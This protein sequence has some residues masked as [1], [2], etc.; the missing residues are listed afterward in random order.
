MIGDCLVASNVTDQVLACQGVLDVL[1]VV[2]ACMPIDRSRR[3]KGPSEMS[4]IECLQRFDRRHVRPL[5][6]AAMIG[7]LSDEENPILLD[8]IEDGGPPPPQEL[9]FEPGPP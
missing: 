4:A 5:R 9:T 7:D 3:T 6:H 8:W 2:C 1:G